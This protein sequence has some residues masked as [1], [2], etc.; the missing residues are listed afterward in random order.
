MTSSRRVASIAAVNN[1][2]RRFGIDVHLYATRWEE[3]SS[4]RTSRTLDRSVAAEQ[5]TLETSGH[6]SARLLTTAPR[7]PEWFARRCRAKPENTATET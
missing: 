6:R 3:I 1:A 2:S 5:T 4:L 7:Q